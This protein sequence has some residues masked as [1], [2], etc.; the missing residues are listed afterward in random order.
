MP[1]GEDLATLGASGA[2]LAIHLSITNLANVVRELTPLYG[3]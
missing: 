1:A 2:T 3:A